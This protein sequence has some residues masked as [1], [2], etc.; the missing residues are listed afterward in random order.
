MADYATDATELKAKLDAKLK[1]AR[2]YNTFFEDL[3]TSLHAEAE[4]AN[5]ALA[6]H[7]V[8]A[9]EFEQGWPDGST[10]LLALG[11]ATS[12]IRLDRDKPT[13]A[14]D[15][16]SETGEKT[17]TFVINDQQAPFTAS[18]VSLAPSNEPKMAPA[19]VAESFIHEL[20]TGA[21]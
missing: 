10:I 15:V 21:A 3:R 12:I 5:S 19:A 4:K 7:D 20:I 1:K 6:F 17:V 8:P 16:K 14:A 11:T 18:R 9:I 2:D 13:L